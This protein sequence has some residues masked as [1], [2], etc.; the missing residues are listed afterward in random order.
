[1]SAFKDNTALGMVRRIDAAVRA[2]NEEIV[3]QNIGNP[4]MLT[5]LVVAVWDWAKHEI[6]YV[7]IGDS[8]MYTMANSDLK[9]IT[10][11]ESVSV[12][13]RGR[14]GKPIMSSGTLAIGKGVTNVIGVPEMQFT[15]NIMPVEEIF[16]IVLATDGFFGSAT[17]GSDHMRTI[18]NQ[19][20]LQNALDMR[21]MLYHDA[22]S[23]DSTVVIARNNDFAAGGSTR[24][25]ELLAANRHYSGS[26]L[27]AFVVSKELIKQLEHS[28]KLHEHDNC[29]AILK[30]ASEMK[31]DLGASAFKRMLDLL[32]LTE[33]TDRM[34]F[35]A[36]LDAMRKSSN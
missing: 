36:V 27:P 19:V 3:T 6:H 24:I 13:M 17:F 34:V 23:D 22:Q 7:S 11:D 16:A 4:R 29:L 5:S 10:S 31:I 30:Y 20:D 32:S 9:L 14:D 33:N 15:V 35:N 18:V 26:G 21:E 2:A 28:I 8:R 1:M 12:I 25:H